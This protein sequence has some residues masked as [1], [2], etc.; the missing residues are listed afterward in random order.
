M[1]LEVSVNK[2]KVKGKVLNFSL[3]E[4]HIGIADAPRRLRGV[5]PGQG[6][7][8]I[9]HVNAD[10]TAL[11]PHNLARQEARLSG[12]R[13]EVKD[14]LPL[15]KIRYGVPAPVVPP[16]DL[17]RDGPKELRVIGSGGRRATEGF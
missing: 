14:G 16:E 3:H 17:V 6:Q 15:L 2:L 10:D 5:P 9:V 8:V 11:R 7:H 1:L 4:L 13:P 12:A